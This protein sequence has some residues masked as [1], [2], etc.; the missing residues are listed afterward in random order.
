MHRHRDAGSFQAASRSD[1]Q[2]SKFELYEK[3]TNLILP[4]YAAWLHRKPPIH[5]PNFCNQESHHPDRIE[6]TGAMTRSAVTTCVRIRGM[7]PREQREQYSR[8]I[9]PDTARSTVV[10]GKD[11]Q[12]AFDKVLDENATGEDVCEHIQPIVDSFL[13]GYNATILAYGQTGSGLYTFHHILTQ[14]RRIRWNKSSPT[15]YALC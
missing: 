14:A 4:I 3:T 8:C 9:F 10:L 12:F 11:Q 2:R 6:K 5:A 15:P 7:L 1:F 13:D